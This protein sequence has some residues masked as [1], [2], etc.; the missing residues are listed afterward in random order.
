MSN[1]DEELKKYANGSPIN[2]EL[3]NKGIGLELKTNIEAFQEGSFPEKLI[4]EIN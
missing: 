3:E 2:A 4:D 1:K